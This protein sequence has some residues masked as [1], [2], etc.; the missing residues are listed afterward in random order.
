MKR[1][2]S[3]NKYPLKRKKAGKMENQGEAITG[4]GH[5]EDSSDPAVDAYGGGRAGLSEV[6]E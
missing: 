1:L 4:S 2:V 5:W 3:T 6:R